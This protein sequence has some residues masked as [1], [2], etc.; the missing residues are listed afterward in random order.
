MRKIFEAILL[1]SVLGGLFA[2]AHDVTK[3]KCVFKGEQVDG[4]PRERFIVGIAQR[5]QTAED[6]DPFPINIRG[7]AVN[8]D[9]EQGDKVTLS[10]FKEAD[11]AGDAT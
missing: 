8:I 6:E 11:C 5:N 9:A 2:E 7:K 10:S 4:E 1:T 3:A